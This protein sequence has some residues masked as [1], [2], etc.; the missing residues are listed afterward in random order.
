MLR[1]EQIFPISGPAKA[2]KRQQRG[3]L[4]RMFA[5]LATVAIFLNLL[6]PMTHNAFAKGVGEGAFIEVCT[7]NGVA[8]IN[9]AELLGDKSTP[10]GS[11]EKAF[12]DACPDC[13]LCWYGTA[14]TLKEGGMGYPYFEENKVG[15]GPVRISAN[16]IAELHWSRPALRAPPAFT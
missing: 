8:K 11:S 14:A 10:L 1:T 13:P 12:C 3:G 16:L 5:F 15:T 7:Q 4:Q 6:V 9:T 2:R